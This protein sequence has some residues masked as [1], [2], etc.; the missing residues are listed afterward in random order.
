MTDDQKLSLL[1]ILKGDLAIAKEA[2]LW[3]EGNKPIDP[4]AESVE[5]SRMELLNNQPDS[6]ASL[7]KAKFAA[8]DEAKKAAG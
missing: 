7:I 8:L 2:A 6:L 4:Y 1:E 3:I 5:I